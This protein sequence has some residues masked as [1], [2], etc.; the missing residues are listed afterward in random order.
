MP[1][2]DP[3]AL[4]GLRP[5]HPLSLLI[6]VSFPFSVIKNYDE[7]NLRG[8]GLVQLTVQGYSLPSPGKSQQQGLRWLITLHP[9]ERAMNG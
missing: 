1:L 6:L 3:K 7:S 5:R 8:N 9:R 4:P 2:P